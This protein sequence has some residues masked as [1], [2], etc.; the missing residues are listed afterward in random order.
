MFKRHD[1]TNMKRIEGVM[2]RGKWISKIEI[3]NM[4]KTLSEKYGTARN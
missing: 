4:L 2:I 1:I 3:G